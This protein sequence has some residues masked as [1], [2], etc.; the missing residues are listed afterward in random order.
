MAWARQAFLLVHHHRLD[1]VEP[2]VSGL[3]VG[4]TVVMYDGSPGHPILA[5]CGGWLESIVSA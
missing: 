2:V 5:P 3:M 1:D 4:C